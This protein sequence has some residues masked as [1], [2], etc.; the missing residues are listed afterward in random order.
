MQ[1]K[2]TDRQQR[3]TQYEIQRDSERDIDK[4]MKREDN[5]ERQRHDRD[6]RNTETD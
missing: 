2:D 5:I 6:M 1:I 4:T 3:N